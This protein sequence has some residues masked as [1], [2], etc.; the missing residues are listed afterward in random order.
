[1]LSVI[2]ESTEQQIHYLYLQ[3]YLPNFSLNTF[4]ERINNRTGTSDWDSSPNIMLLS[5]FFLSL[6]S[7]REKKTSECV[8]VRENVCFVETFLS[9]LHCSQYHNDRERIGSHTHIH[10]IGQ[11]YKNTHVPLFISPHCRTLLFFSQSFHRST[12][13]FNDAHD[14]YIRMTYTVSKCLNSHKLKLLW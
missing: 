13:D 6:L 1:M 4:F 11:M 2:T 8:Y 9:C 5:F 14:Q 7:H 12:M 10:R 3:F